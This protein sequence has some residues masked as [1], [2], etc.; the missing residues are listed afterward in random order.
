MTTLSI[1]VDLVA[2]Q[3]LR[4]LNPHEGYC[5]IYLGGG[6][7]FALCVLLWRRRAR[8]RIRARA[9]LRLF[10]S[11]ALW[12]HRSTLLDLKLYFMHG[13]LTLIAYGMFETSSE[14]W[15]TATDSALSA[16]AGPGPHLHAHNGIV[17][18]IATA[19]QLLALE[20][21]YWVLHYAFHKVPALWELH[22]VHHSAEVMT[23][24]SEWR[25]HPIEFVAFTNVLTLANGSVYGAM[26]WLFGPAAQPLTLFQINAL[27]VLHF[28]TFHHLRHSNV[29]IAATGWLGHLFHSPAHHQIHHS[30]DPHHFDRNFGY[31]LSIWDW[32][33]NTLYVPER[34]IKVNFGVAGVR[35][36]QGLTDTLIR[37]VVSVAHNLQLA[38]LIP[39]GRP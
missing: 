20:L 9:F 6:L 23:P 30:S 8:S 29:W 39:N 22:K 16:L 35:P 4:F 11:R 5:W 19:S 34:H 18:A 26:A 12:L 7:L 17:G 27:F 37:P 28:A 32:A 33:F 31:A 2:Y 24:L 10:G 15:R 1:A 36:Y 25:Q 14:A 38:S 3:F 13:M 21:G